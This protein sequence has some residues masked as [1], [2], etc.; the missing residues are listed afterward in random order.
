MTSPSGSTASP[1]TAGAS[2]AITA[3]QSILAAQHAAYF[4]YS[5]IGV[6]L[7]DPTQVSRIRDLQAEHRATR[8]DLMTQ[9]SSV[10]AAPVAAQ[11]SYTPPEKLTDAVAAQRWA[12]ALEEACSAGYRFLLVAAATGTG[13]V[14][15][16][17]E[18]GTAATEIGTLRKQALTGL[19]GSAQAARYWRALLTPATPTVPFPGI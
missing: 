16:A 1:N 19:S 8:D 6:R 18:T 7:T 9:L 12:L 10:G 15:A 3:L 4:A 2:A 5:M 14:A 13:T 17:T 11:P